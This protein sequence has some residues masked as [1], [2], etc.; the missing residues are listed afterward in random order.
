MPTQRNLKDANLHLEKYLP[1][2]A[3]TNYSDSLDLGSASPGMSVEDTELR[4]T[5]PALPN[6]TD[7][8]KTTTLTLQDSADD[9]SFADVDPLHQ[10]QIA[11]VAST[12]SAA[13]TKRLRLPST[14]RRY[15]RFAQAVPSG[16]GDNTAG[17]VEYDLLT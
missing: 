14:I 10:I 6:N 8:S 9:S 1:A 17:L 13:A 2:A 16:A 4:V 12:G 15:V 3:A 7:S 5:I 11:G